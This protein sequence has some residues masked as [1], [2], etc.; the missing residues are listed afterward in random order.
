MYKIKVE[1][2]DNLT[3]GWPP[4]QAVEILIADILK[5]FSV[6][7]V[8]YDPQDARVDGAPNALLAGRRNHHIKYRFPFGQ[9]CTCAE[10]ISLG[11]QDMY[12]TSFF[13]Q[14]LAIVAGPRPEL[15]EESKSDPRRA[16]D[17]ISMS[18]ISSSN[19]GE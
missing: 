10:K 12:A 7:Q 5:S 3:K 1:K 4:V 8:R 11:G 9:W 15:A 13:D 17:H 2:V 16:Q 19:L 14:N 6:Y 18:V